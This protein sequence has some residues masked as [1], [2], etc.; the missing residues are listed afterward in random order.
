MSDGINDTERVNEEEPKKEEEI[1]TPTEKHISL[2]ELEIQ[3]KELE[4]LK[5]KLEQQYFIVVGRV[6]MVSEQVNYL[7]ELK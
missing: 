7:K 3:L 4:D 1:K 2:K 6:K 5:T